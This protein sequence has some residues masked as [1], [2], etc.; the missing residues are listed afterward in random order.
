MTAMVMMAATI[1]FSLLLES[2]GMIVAII[3]F[4]FYI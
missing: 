4:S 3:Y 1:D 2:D